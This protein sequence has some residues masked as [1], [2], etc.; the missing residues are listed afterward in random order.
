MR[1]ILDLPKH[2]LDALTKLAARKRLSRAELIRQ[3]IAEYLERHSTIASDEAFGLWAARG[4]DGLS[5]EARV[6]NEWARW[7]EEW[8]K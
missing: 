2:Q 7:R 6:R 4:E 8:S 1:T 3:A 5:H